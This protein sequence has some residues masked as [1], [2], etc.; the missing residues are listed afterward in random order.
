ME[1]VRKWRERNGKASETKYSSPKA[2]RTLGN[3]ELLDTI[4]TASNTCSY[5]LVLAMIEKEIDN[6]KW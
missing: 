1:A 6:E 3:D 5:Y 4:S 2:E